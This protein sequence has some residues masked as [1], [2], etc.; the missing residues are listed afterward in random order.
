M[1]DLAD[2]LRSR[3]MR[4]RFSGDRR[5]F[6]IE[7]PLASTSETA[8]N[9][10]ALCAGCEVHLPR[11]MR[12]SLN[13][14]DG[15]QFVLAEIRRYRFGSMG[16]C[17]VEGQPGQGVWVRLRHLTRSDWHTFEARRPLPAIG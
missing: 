17:E 2:E 6:S 8:D 12:V 13:I 15:L 3:G 11:S 9:P 5:L 14:E 4:H 10:D 7:G 16:F 1:T